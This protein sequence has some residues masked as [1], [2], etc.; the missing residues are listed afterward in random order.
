MTRNFATFVILTI[1]GCAFLAGFVQTSY[2]GQLQALQ[3]DISAAQYRLEKNRERITQMMNYDTSAVVSYVEWMF[4]AVETARE[5]ELL[6]ATLTP[7]ERQAYLAQI[8]AE[9]TAANDQILITYTYTIEEFFLENPSADEYYFA[10]REISGFDLVIERTSWE[11]W[12]PLMV[13][14]IDYFIEWWG[15]F[16]ESV[17]PEIIAYPDIPEFMYVMWLSDLGSALVDVTAKLQDQITQLEDEMYWVQTTVDQL[18]MGITVTTAAT[19]LAA[20]MAS[21]IEDRTT[22]HNF[23]ALRAEITGDRALIVPRKD[24]ITIP[25]L[26]IAIIMAVVGALIPII[27][28]LF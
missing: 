9:L 14:E 2:I 7:N 1:A 16:P 24:R 19:V 28:T 3:D 22:K 23:S 5:Y 4:K 8:A 11:Y 18:G 17:I 20:T 25:M 6:A 27:S 10:E 26:F 12:M 15:E 13:G 21:R